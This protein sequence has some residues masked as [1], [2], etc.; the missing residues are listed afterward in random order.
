MN[1]VNMTETHLQAEQEHFKVIA[2][3]LKFSVFLQL[4]I[5]FHIFL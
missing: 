3:Y 2:I 4:I 5:E 1:W